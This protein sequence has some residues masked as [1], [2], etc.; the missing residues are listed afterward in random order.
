M[1]VNQQ[2]LAIFVQVNI[3]GVRWRNRK[4][5]TGGAAQVLTSS[6]SQG[7]SSAQWALTLS[8]HLPKGDT[9]PPCR[10]VLW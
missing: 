10:L 5:V 1:F 3:N 2:D 7:S 6:G 8:P 9:A 4:E